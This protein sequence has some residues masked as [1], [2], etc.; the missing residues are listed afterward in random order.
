[1]DDICYFFFI[2]HQTNLIGSIFIFLKMIL[3]VEAGTRAFQNC[4]TWLKH[5]S[6]NRGRD[7]VLQ[8]VDF[9]LQQKQYFSLA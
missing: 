5:E 2:N 7:S 4:N 1:M 6:R 8:F 9:S 3:R